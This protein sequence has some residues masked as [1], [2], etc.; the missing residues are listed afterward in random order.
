MMRKQVSSVH[1][2]DPAAHDKKNATHRGA[3]AIKDENGARM[4]VVTFTATFTQ[5]VTT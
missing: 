4:I 2:E 3:F 1:S 5:A